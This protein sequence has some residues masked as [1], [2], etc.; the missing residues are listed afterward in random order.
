[1]SL[2]EDVELLL[3]ALFEPSAN[4]DDLAAVSDT[5][6]AEFL[7]VAKASEA[8]LVVA[9]VAVKP[10]LA[11]KSLLAVKDAE[12]V[13]VEDLLL[14]ELLLA[15]PAIAGPVVEGPLV[16]EPTLPEVLPPLAEL[17]LEFEVAVSEAVPFLVDA[18]K[19]AV[20]FFAEVALEVVARLPFAA[21]AALSA[22][23]EFFVRPAFTVDP[24]AALLVVAE[25]L[26]ALA[27]NAL[28]ELLL[29]LACWAS[30]S[31]AVLLFMVLKTFDV[32]LVYALESVVEVLREVFKLD[33]KLLLLVTFEVL[34]IVN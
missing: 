3:E 25:F 9:K 4:C 13:N 16:V 8:F 18:A 5:A 19:A 17:L 24:N 30:D 7:D 12:P 21:N 10:L 15:S 31:V 27:L 29:A 22:T 20:A 2:V 34:S 11:A 6:D 28:D 23:E 33:A 14:A 32:S 26:E 1:V